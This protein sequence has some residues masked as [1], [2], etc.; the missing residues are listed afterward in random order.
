MRK[1][2]VQDPHSPSQYRAN[3]IVSNMDA[4]YEAFSIQPGDPMYIAPENRVR[5]W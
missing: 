5:I 3:G 2:L 4:F 1:R